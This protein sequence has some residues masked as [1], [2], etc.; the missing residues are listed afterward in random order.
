CPPDAPEWF[1]TAFKDLLS[2][3]LGHDYNRLLCAYLAMEKSYGFHS[4]STTLKTDGRPLAVKKWIKDA[5]EKKPAVGSL[6]VFERQWWDW[7]TKLQPA[8][9]DKDDDGR[10]I[11]MS[12]C[13]ADW[14]TLMVPG[15]NGLWSVIAALGWWGEAEKKAD[16][17]PGASWRAA[18]EDVVWA[19]NGLAAAPK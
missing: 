3:N 10:P 16:I 13:G 6:S 8:W 2:A 15:I 14:G 9:R 11:Q 7:W 19:C 17:Q 4:G 5:R 18:V 12:E 1:T